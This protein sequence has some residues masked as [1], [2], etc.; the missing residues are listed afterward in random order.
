MVQGRNILRKIRSKERT[1]S[2]GLSGRRARPPPWA[3][4]MRGPRADTGKKY[5]KRPVQNKN[6]ILRKQL[7]SKPVT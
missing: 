2:T 6:R 1:V 5:V 3:S 4:R 7:G